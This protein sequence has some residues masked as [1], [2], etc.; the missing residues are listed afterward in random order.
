M[1]KS[2]YKR[3][4]AL[5]LRRWSLAHV[6]GMG[7]RKSFSA[8]EQVSD[9]TFPASYLTKEFYHTPEHL[10]NLKTSV[11]TLQKTRV[12]YNLCTKENFFRTVFHGRCTTLNAFAEQVA[13]TTRTT[14]HC[15]RGKKGGGR[16]IVKN[17]VGAEKACTVCK[18]MKGL[19]NKSLDHPERRRTSSP[20]GV[21][22]YM[23]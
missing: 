12:F 6:H 20:F 23:I 4:Q 8:C 2:F 7:K 22:L 3:L 17:L 10:L 13:L 15:F 16:L 21:Y 5:L 19:G 11:L 9:D 1:S 18:R 14:C